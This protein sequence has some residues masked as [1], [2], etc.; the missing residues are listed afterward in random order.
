MLNN[1]NIMGRLTADPELRHT[2]GG[3]AVATFRIAV[4]RDYK[5]KATGERG[6]DYLTVVSWRNTAE[7]ASRYL[8][9]GLLVIVSGRIQVREYTDK[10]GQKR[11]AT[12][13]V[14]ENLYFGESRQKPVEEP[15]VDFQDVDDDEDI[16]F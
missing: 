16:P 8:Y 1:I 12:E 13:I 11:Y 10:E 6:V 7:F 5:D 15:Q 14:A 2:Q 3:V 4:N 9:K